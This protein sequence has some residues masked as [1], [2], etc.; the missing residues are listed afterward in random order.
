[1]AELHTISDHARFLQVRDPLKAGKRPEPKTTTDPDFSEDMSTEA[2]L[3][4][5]SEIGFEMR[6]I[7]ATLARRATD[8]TMADME[9]RIDEAL[10]GFCR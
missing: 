5:L 6:Q 3:S 4:R 2:M 7:K 10:R 8:A 9:A 1:M